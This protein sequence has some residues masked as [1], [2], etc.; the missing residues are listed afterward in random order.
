MCEKCFRTCDVRV[1]PYCVGKKNFSK[2]LKLEKANL[3]DNNRLDAFWNAQACLRPGSIRCIPS[4]QNWQHGCCR[5]Y[6]QILVQAMLDHFPLLLGPSCSPELRALAAYF[7]TCPSMRK[8]ENIKAA[9]FRE[10]LP[11]SARVPSRILSE[12]HL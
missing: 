9:A 5:A 1:D 12:V 4:I 11:G 8:L 3:P 6:S 2:Y 7:H 10:V